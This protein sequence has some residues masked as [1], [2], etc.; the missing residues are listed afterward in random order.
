MTFIIHAETASAGSATK[1]NEEKNP[2]PLASAQFSVGGATFR[3]NMSH[4]DAFAQFASSKG[5]TWF[6]RDLD[7]TPTSELLKMDSW[8]LS[9]RQVTRLS[10]S[11][12]TVTLTFSNGKLIKLQTKSSNH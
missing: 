12:G 8:L 11:S 2:A 7:G 3:L 4:A 1:I 5:V 6:E 9:Y 10:A